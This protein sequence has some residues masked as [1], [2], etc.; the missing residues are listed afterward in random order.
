MAGG[1]RP[2]TAGH[3]DRRRV[4]SPQGRGGGHCTRPARVAGDN[5]DASPGEKMSALTTDWFF[6]IPAIR[7]AEARA[8]QI[9]SV[10]GRIR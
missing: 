4:A 2:L 10:W 8:G 5:P 9:R 3:R 6:R 1:A 7:L